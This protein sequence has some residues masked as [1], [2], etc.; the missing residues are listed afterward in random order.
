MKKIISLLL[1]LALFAT[2]CVNNSLVVQAEDMAVDAEKMALQ[3][4]LEQFEKDFPE[5]DIRVVN[6][7]IHIVVNDITDIPGMS[8]QPFTTSV[9]NSNGGSYRN[10]QVPWYETYFPYSQVYM[11]REVVDATLIKMSRPDIYNWVKSQIG[12]GITSAA[13]SAAAVYVWGISIPAAVV[14]ILGSFAYNAAANLDYWSLTN[15]KAQSSQG[16]AYVVRGN[17]NEGVYYVFYAAWTGSS[18][19]TYLG[20]EATWYAGVYDI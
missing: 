3:R 9:T 2:V 13:I 17:T 7:G 12:E 6:N 18:C 11:N 10:F 4:A 16:K 8:V 20:Y 14:S 5:A 19:P 15:A 1:T